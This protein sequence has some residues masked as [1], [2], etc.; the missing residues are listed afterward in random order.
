[1][2]VKPNEF[3][4]NAGGVLVSRRILEEQSPLKWAFREASVNPVDNG[5][6]FLSIDDDDEF[7]ETPGN[8]VVADFNTV[9]AIEPAIIEIYLLPVGSDLQLVRENDGTLVFYDNQTGKPLNE[10]SPRLGSNPTF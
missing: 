7:L 2:N 1:L 5:W 9:A 4:K 6:R 8:L 3:I 10:G